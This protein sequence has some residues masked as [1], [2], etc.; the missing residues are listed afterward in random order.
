MIRRLALL[1]VAI[2][3]AVSLRA[4][5]LFVSISATGTS[6]TT[7]FDRPSQGV[8]VCNKS[9]SANIVHVRLF[10]DTETPAASTTAKSPIAVGA[11]KSFDFDFYGQSGSGFKYISVIAASSGTATVE[12]DY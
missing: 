10:T 5:V 6:S 1:I 3:A 2:L 9:T 12:V 4:E 7:T 11:C 8:L